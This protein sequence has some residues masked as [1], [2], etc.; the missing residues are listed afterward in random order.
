[1][2]GEEL[3]PGIAFCMFCQNLGPTIA[4]TLM[5]VIFSSTLPG[6]LR[7]H[8]P[9]VDP[10]AVVSAGSTDFRTIV[11]PRELPGVLVA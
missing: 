4:L 5:N 1:M 6:E 9:L 2:G 7:Q 10:A 11:P 3:A 8:A